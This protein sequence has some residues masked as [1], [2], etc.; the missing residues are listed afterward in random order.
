MK[1]LFS[2]L[3]TAYICIAGIV[4]YGSEAYNVSDLT[5]LF[6][7]LNSAN[8]STQIILVSNEKESQIKAT[9]EA[10]DKTSA[11]WIKS[12]PSISAVIGE[13][14]FTLNKKEG[15]L[16]SPAGV[17][18]IGT[19]FGAP[20]TPSIT[21][22]PYKNTTKNDYWIDEV[23]S[24]DYNTWVNFAGD[25]YS[26][27]KSFERLKISEYTYA[28]VIEYNINPIIKG[29]GSAIFF[30]I[31]KG[32]NIST[33]G[34]TAVS[35]SN[36]LNLLGWLNPDKNPI[37]IQGTK[38]M[39]SKMPYTSTDKILYPIKVKINEKEVGFDVPPRIVSGRTLIPVRTVFEDLGAK[40]SWDESTKTVTVLKASTEVKLE[41]GSKLAYVGKKQVQLDVPASVINGRTM[42][43]LRFIAEELGLM[44]TW[45]ASRRI[46]SIGT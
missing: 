30:H 12:F 18:R 13:K 5:A 8:G 44:V 15:D 45:D 22:L 34:C 2:F 14:G 25:P 1:I 19:A 3:L 37:I 7:K 9:V 43:P 33:S 42:I 35:E 29:N 41:S 24:P 31:W 11:G 39:L 27:W 21:K 16:K 38:A 6:D 36:M 10:F 4:I 32:S 28:F 40:V 26:R 46:V 17:F 23:S 20:N